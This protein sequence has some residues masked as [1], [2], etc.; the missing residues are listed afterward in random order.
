MPGF[1]IGG[2]GGPLTAAPSVD[3]L[4]DH[5]FTMTTFMGMD[6]TTD[7][8]IQLKDITLP[9]KV[10]ETLEIKC[11]GTTYKFAKSANYTDLVLTFYGT[12]G[13]VDRIEDLENSVHNVNTGIGDFNTYLNDVT[14]NFTDNMG[15][16]LSVLLFSNCFLSNTKFGDLTYGSSDIK[17]ITV[18]L[19]INYYTITQAS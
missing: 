10:I 15:S 9:E 18:T 17:L 4:R 14:V 5:R 11:P 13:L 1:K 2:D 7:P 12:S 16:P 19:K 8:F 6:A 3:L